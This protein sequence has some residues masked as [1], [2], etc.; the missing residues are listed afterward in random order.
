MAGGSAGG[1]TDAGIAT[2]RDALNCGTPIAVNGV[3]QAGELQLFEVDPALFPD[4]LCNDGTR[5]VIYFRPAATAAASTKWVISLRGGGGCGTG[6]ACAA[7]WCSCANTTRCPFAAVTTNF[8]INNMSG[9]G[10]RGNTVGGIL[11]RAPPLPNP[12]ADYNHAQFVYCSSDGWS[13]NARAVSYDVTHPITGQPTTYTMHFLGSRILDANLAVLR[14]DRV[15][16][17]TYTLGG[18]S[19][20]MPDLDD[21]TE[22]VI[23]GDSAGG[24]GVIHNLDL[25]ASLLRANHVGC[26]G[27]ASCPPTVHGLIDAV[28]GPDQSR[29]DWSQ[30][31]GADAGLATWAALLDAQSRSP[32]RAGSRGDSSCAAF[33]LDGGTGSACE[34]ISHVVRHHVTTPFFVRMALL[35]SLI[36]N[37]YAE[38]GAR[39][40]VLGPFV[41]N[42]AGIPVTFATVLRRELAEFPSMAANAEE[43]ASF[44]KPPGVFGPSCAN[45]DT[46]HTSSEVYGVV[47]ATDAGLPYR[48]FDVFGFWRDGGTPPAVLSS[49]PLRRDTICP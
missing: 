47:I 5:P 46:I 39:D 13:G 33:H 1:A 16:P 26:D 7:R 25:I 48:L 17:L 37:N 20:P 41:D 23:A 3:G 36:S 6:P 35:D 11:D 43:G 28:V 2:I 34:D 8:T 15:A 24:A 21:A 30:A 32:A 12:L 9:G 10:R 14:Q 31:V 18:A 29:L 42:D 38:S 49:D 40:P 45:H 19:T 22:V 4:A 27:G 44:T